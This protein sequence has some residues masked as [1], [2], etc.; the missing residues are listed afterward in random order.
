M[1]K[2]IARLRIRWALRRSTERE[3]REMLTLTI[4]V[5]RRCTHD[6]GHALSEIPQSEDWHQH[7]RSRLHAKHHHWMKVFYPD[8]GAKKYRSTLHAELADAYGQIDRLEKLCR[9]NGVDPT[10]PNG[11]PF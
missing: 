8:D 10:D 3:V 4:M 11:M 9:A 2:M 5:G 1:M 7:L 6:L